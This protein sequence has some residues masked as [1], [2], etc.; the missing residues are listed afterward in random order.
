MNLNAYIKKLG[1]AGVVSAL[2]LLA[3]WLAIALLLDGDV[4]YSVLFAILAFILD[5]IDGYVARKT[6]KV[7]ELGRQLDS[8]IDLVGYS[9]Y[10]ALLTYLELLPGWEG[11]LVGYAIILFGILRLIKFNIDGYAEEGSVHYYRGVVV[12]HLSLATIIFLILSTQF[13]IPSFVIALVLMLLS[14]LQISNIKTRKTGTLPFWY[15][16]AFVLTIS[17]LIWLP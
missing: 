9:L 5:S 2:A 16:V 6:N 13:E 11:I 4:K 8:M 12:C 7:S 1:V 3:A 14:V 10:A 15:G 17:A